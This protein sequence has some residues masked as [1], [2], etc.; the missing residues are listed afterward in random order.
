MICVTPQGI[1]QQAAEKA[2]G[3]HPGTGQFRGE[4]A[5][6]HGM[7]GDGR[8]GYQPGLSPVPAARL[9]TVTGGEGP[10]AS[11]IAGHQGRA[12]VQM[13]DAAS[14][15]SPGLAGQLGRNAPSGIPGQ[16]APHVAPTGVGA[17]FR[18]SPRR[19]F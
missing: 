16:P 14:A 8:M 6:G 11:A 5:A 4:I 12:Q 1:A 15:A 10:L 17:Q 9:A 18:T 7:T 3:R 13:L 19:G 2:A